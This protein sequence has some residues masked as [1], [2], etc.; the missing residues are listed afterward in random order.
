MFLQPEWTVRPEEG[1]QSP[2][3]PQ[4]IGEG[5]DLGVG[6]NLS[7]RRTFLS[8]TPDAAGVAADEFVVD[9]GL[10]DG[11]EEPVGLGDGRG[12]SRRRQ[13]LGARGAVI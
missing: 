4:R 1:H 13:G 3:R 5:I 11:F 2:A 7:F 9:R 8:S 6:G 12:R 10:H